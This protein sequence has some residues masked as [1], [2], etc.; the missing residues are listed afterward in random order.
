M[1]LEV[2]DLSISYGKGNPVVHGVSFSVDKGKILAIIGESGSGKTT[3]LRAIAGL[4][5]PDEGTI[6]L[7]GEMWLDAARG[8]FVPPRHLQGLRL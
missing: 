1:L 2:N 3:V 8:L 4:D 5:R 6:S 7:D